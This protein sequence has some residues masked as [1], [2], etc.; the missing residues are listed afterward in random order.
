M[1]PETASHY[2]R[3]ARMTPEE[4]DAEILR[5]VFGANMTRIFPAIAPPSKPEP[6]QPRKPEPHGDNT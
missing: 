5:E 2:N 4:R 6:T 1:N 3:L